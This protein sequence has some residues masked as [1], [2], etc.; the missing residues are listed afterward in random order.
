MSSTSDPT[1]NPED[2]NPSGITIAQIA[3]K[4]KSLPKMETAPKNMKKKTKNNTPQKDRRVTFYHFILRQHDD[5]DHTG[6]K[7]NGFRRQRCVRNRV[8]HSV[9]NHHL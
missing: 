6:V 4:T 2:G 8:V 3:I 9:S 5:D 1:S 7:R